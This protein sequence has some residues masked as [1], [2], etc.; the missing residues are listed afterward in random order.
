MVALGVFEILM[1]VFPM[2]IRQGTSSPTSHL[3]TLRHSLELLEHLTDHLSPQLSARLVIRR[4]L[5]SLIGIGSNILSDPNAETCIVY[6]ADYLVI[7]YVSL[8]SLVYRYSL[9]YI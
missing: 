5:T 4:G 7:L 3:E 1:S 9:V 6:L 8:S 2:I